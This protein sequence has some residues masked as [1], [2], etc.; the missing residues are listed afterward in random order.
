MC[1]MQ[2]LVQIIEDHRLSVPWLAASSSDG[3]KVVFVR[4][5]DEPLLSHYCALGPGL[6]PIFAA[7]H[8]AAPAA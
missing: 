1:H 4:Q 5:P 3:R 7:L 6:C 2:E 8:P